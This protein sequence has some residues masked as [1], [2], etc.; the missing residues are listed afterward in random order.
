VSE[1]SLL[2]GNVNLVGSSDSTFESHGDTTCLSTLLSTSPYVNLFINGDST[3]NFVYENGASLPSIVFDKSILHPVKIDG[4][5]TFL[6]KG[7]LLLRNG[8]LDT[9]GIDVRVGI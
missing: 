5:G 6:V 8:V 4:T 2:L 7:D 3:Q 9:N 1:R